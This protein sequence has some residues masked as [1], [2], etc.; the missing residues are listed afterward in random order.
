MGVSVSVLDYSGDLYAG[1]HG[2]VG[3][4]VAPGWRAGINGEVWGWLAV[5]LS[6]RRRN[7]DRRGVQRG[8]GGGDR[9]RGGGG[10][11]ADVGVGVSGRRRDAGRADARG[12][13]D[14]GG[15]VSVYAESAVCGDL[16]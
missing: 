8:A 11:A 2:A 3:R 12:C 7:V 5:A 13:G 14:G 4:G 16:G 10:V 9:V 15:A 6:Q 1:V